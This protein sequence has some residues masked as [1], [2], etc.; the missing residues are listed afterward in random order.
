MPFVATLVDDNRGVLNK[1]KFS[2]VF[3]YVSNEEAKEG[4]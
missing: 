2:E 3:R 4:M 1:T